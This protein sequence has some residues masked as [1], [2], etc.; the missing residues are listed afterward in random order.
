MSF[1]LYKFA[2]V[3]KKK[4]FFQKMPESPKEWYRVSEHTQQTYVTGFSKW[5]SH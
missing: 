1:K 3:E 4:N 2:S 5:Q